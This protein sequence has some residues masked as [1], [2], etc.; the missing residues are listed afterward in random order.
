MTRVLLLLTMGGC[1]WVTEADKELVRPHLDEDG[2]GFSNTEDCAPNDPAINPRATEI[3]YD[4]VDQNCDGLNDFDQDG[5]Q[6]A[7][8]EFAAQQEEAY[9]DSPDLMIEATDCCDTSPQ[10]SPKQGETYYDGVDQNCDGRNDFDQDGDNAEPEVDPT[11][12]TSVTIVCEVDTWTVGG[13]CNDLDIG[14]GPE[15]DDPAYD[16]LDSN[17][18]GD[19]YEYDADRDGADSNAHGGLDCNDAAGDVCPAC[20]EIWYNSVDNNCD[21][22]N[23][24]D[25]DGDGY[26]PDAWLADQALRYPDAQLPGGDCNDEDVDQNPA[27]PELTSDSVDSDCDGGISTFRVVG[28]KDKGWEI[29]NPVSLHYGAIGSQLYLSVNADYLYVPFSDGTSDDAYDGS[30]AILWD[31]NDTIAT[32]GSTAYS[33]VRWDSSATPTN[34]SAIA[35]HDLAPVNGQIYNFSL[36]N[37]VNGSNNLPRLAAYRTD[38]GAASQRQ[39][40]APRNLYTDATLAVDSDDTLH[41]FACSDVGTHLGYLGVDSTGTSTYDELEDYAFPVCAA[42]TYNGNRLVVEEDG[43]LVEYEFDVVAGS[44]SLT[45]VGNTP[46]VYSAYDLDIP[47]GLSQR[48]IVVADRYSNQVVVIS[49]NGGVNR[50]TTINPIR[51]DLREDTTG[52]PILGYVSQAGTAAILELTEFGFYEVEITLPADFTA[53]D[54]TVW[55]T[56][57]GVYTAVLGSYSDGTSDVAIGRITL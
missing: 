52:N 30:T 54:I 5:D 15:V 27:A 45:A 38:S 9:R 14:I 4:G 25:Q 36:T 6:R 12:A 33:M 24:F 43:A 55:P 2:D 16:G 17:C 35:A 37:Q 32:V 8:S 57:D 13:D 53:Q 48:R 19:T 47:A 42:D 1:T 50:S 10:I 11:V 29:Q 41:G 49:E 26:I 23:D 21:N 46:L 39:V 44:L 7:S 3:W 31:L 28:L 56:T 22:A 51:V 18:D 40:S 34:L 20:T